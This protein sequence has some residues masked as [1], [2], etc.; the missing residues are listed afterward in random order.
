MYIRK[1]AAA[2]G[3]ACGAALA[4]APLAAAD[5]G[6]TVT[7][8]LDSEIASQNSLFAV[9]AELSNAATTPATATDPYIS[10]TNLAHDAPHLVA[11]PDGVSIELMQC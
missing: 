10:L 11:A 7:S 4:F 6:S 1:L 5:L 2:A 8:T 3:F 9:Y